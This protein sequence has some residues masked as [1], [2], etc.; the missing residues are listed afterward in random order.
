[1]AILGVESKGGQP[2]VDLAKRDTMI[3]V[4]PQCVKHTQQNAL[5]LLSTRAFCFL[6]GSGGMPPQE[7][8]KNKPPEIEFG[9][10]LD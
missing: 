1:V 9:D 3:E 6:Q 4:T 2:R 7:I 5:I 8:L 10:N